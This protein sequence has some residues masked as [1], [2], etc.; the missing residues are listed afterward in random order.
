M[1]QEEKTQAIEDLFKSLRAMWP[2]LKPNVKPRK[3]VAG[4]YNF[5]D[6]TPGTVFPNPVFKFFDSPVDI[7]PIMAEK[8]MSEGD[9]YPYDNITLSVNEEFH[10]REKEFKMNP[11]ETK[12]TLKD[13]RCPESM[14]AMIL[15]LKEDGNQSGQDMLVYDGGTLVKKVFRRLATLRLL[16]AR[17]EDEVQYALKLLVDYP[18]IP[19]ST[20]EVCYNEAYHANLSPLEIQMLED[21]KEDMEVYDSFIEAHM[22]E[23]FSAKPDEFRMKMKPLKSPGTDI[24]DE[25]GKLFSKKD[26][27]LLPAAALDTTC[28]V[29]DPTAWAEYQ[30]EYGAEGEQ[31][32]VRQEG[33]AFVKYTWFS[34]KCFLLNLIKGRVFRRMKG[35]LMGLLHN[36]KW[37]CDCAV[38]G[39]SRENSRAFRW[40]NPDGLGFLGKDGKPIPPAPGT[41]LPDVSDDAAYE[42]I[43][44]KLREETVRTAEGIYIRMVSPKEV[45]EALRDAA[46]HLPKLVKS[47][48]KKGN[49][50][51]R[52]VRDFAGAV[53]LRI[54]AI[55]PGRWTFNM[56]DGTVI[57]PYA[58]PLEH[59]R[60]GFP[61]LKKGSRF[62][63][64]WNRELLKKPVYGR[65]DWA[66]DVS[67]FET[68]STSSPDFLLAAAGTSERRRL[69]FEDAASGWIATTLGRSYHGPS[70]SSGIG[71][72]SWHSLTTGRF[73][74]SVDVGYRNKGGPDVAERV[75]KTARTDWRY[76]MANAMQ[77][78]IEEYQINA[79]N[80]FS[81]YLDTMATYLVDDKLVTSLTHAG[82]DDQGGYDQSDAISDE[83]LWK[84]IESNPACQEWRRKTHMSI[85]KGGAHFAIVRQRSVITANEAASTWKAFLMEHKMISDFVCLGLVQTFTLVPDFAEDLQKVFTE[86]SLGSIKS[87]YK[88]AANA[89]RLIESDPVFFNEYLSAMYEEESPRGRVMATVLA[90]VGY[91]IGQTMKVPAD[92][93]AQFLRMH[94][95]FV[96]TGD[97]T[98]IEAVVK[99]PFNNP[100]PKYQI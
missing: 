76:N 11:A 13:A 54:R 91:Q 5:T 92:L 61:N 79:K 85:E 45:V 34:Q 12:M 35:L 48:S 41:K 65:T 69:Y 53:A 95:A 81:S 73:C 64:Y 26:H 8:V 90:D 99:E 44:G 77:Y 36:P 96:E 10:R 78:V 31:R 3:V 89:L 66:L 93:T 75:R 40:N 100:S 59:S 43:Q 9:F 25:H 50:V 27:W 39:A 80:P 70:T 38:D 82:S 55:Y 72:T 24:V 2:D 21:Y 88:G 28:I 94:L 97:V 63:T 32:P 52:A 49:T 30:A 29:T 20:L 57:K 33:N 16:R 56:Y 15:P 71:H 83:D 17:D 46:S 22:L 37:E 4:R 60:V 74:A 47:I 84:H 58:I 68:F 19:P 42:S 14:V 87:Y 67:H 23:M 7:S 86:L 62:D 1:T 18:V 51:I 6:Y 98:K